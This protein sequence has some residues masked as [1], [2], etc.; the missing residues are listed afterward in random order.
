MIP[1]FLAAFSIARCILF[2]GITRPAGRAEGAKIAARFAGISSN[3]LRLFLLFAG[4][5]S[6][7]A[8]SNLTSVQS[9]LATSW[10]LSPLKVQTAKK[11]SQSGSSVA[12]DLQRHRTVK[13]Y[14]ER[15]VSH[16]HRTATQLDRFPVFARHQLVV[17]KS[18]LRVNWVGLADSS[19]EDSSDLTVPAGAL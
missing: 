6:I 18:L 1:A 9:S 14:V 10:R 16:P 8:R 2:R 4:G 7:K 15:F 3:F 11:G 19:K 17:V 13:I 5:R 12:D